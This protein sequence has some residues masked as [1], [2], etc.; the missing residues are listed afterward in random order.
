M[1]PQT[2][3]DENDLKSTWSV[4]GVQDLSLNHNYPSAIKVV[5]IEHWGKETV[6]ANIQGQT[7]LDLYKSA[8]K[9]ITDSGDKHHVFIEDFVPLENGRLELITGS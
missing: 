5:Y 3:Q 6:E 9:C 2:A 7:W 4:R 8:D 1:K